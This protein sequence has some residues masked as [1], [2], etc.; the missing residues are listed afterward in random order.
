MLLTNLNLSFIIYNR[1]YA[2]IVAYYKGVDS[3]PPIPKYTKEEI[4]L[5]AFNMVKEKGYDMLT[6][7]DLAKKLGTSTRPIF[8]AF[9]N[10]DAL[11]KEII[12][13]SAELFKKYKKDEIEKKEHPEYKATGMA[14]IRFA[15]EEK[16][17][18]K[19]LFMRDRT[20]EKDINELSISDEVGM[21]TQNLAISNEEAINFHIKMWVMMHGF[22]T[23]LATGYLD[24]DFETIS[25]ITTSVYNAI[26]DGATKWKI[27]LK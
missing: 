23:M 16:N 14:Y 25:K 18:F 26:K 9:E 24:L 3:M 2:T 13:K 12:Y 17:L 7:R 27:L 22:A 5:I 1:R 8:T 21:I 15:K 10:M 4:T 11:K 19:L 20:N 6:A